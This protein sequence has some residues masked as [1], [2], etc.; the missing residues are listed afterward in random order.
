MDETYFVYVLVS[1]KDSTFYV[2]YANDLD[3]RY[4]EHIDGEVA[5]TK[6]RRH[7]NLVYYEVGKNRYDALHREKYLKSGP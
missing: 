3:K 7:L 4:R 5:S 6:H 1:N 2:G